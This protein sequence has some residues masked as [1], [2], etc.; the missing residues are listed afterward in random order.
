MLVA[1]SALVEIAAAQTRPDFTGTWVL[2]AQRSSV[3]GGGRGDPTAGGRRTGPGGGQGGGTG[4][5]VPPERLTIRQDANTITI[6]QDFVDR[7]VTVTYRLD[8]K[9]AANTLPMGRDRV[10]PNAMYSSGWRDARLRT[11]I[12]ATIVG[13]GGSREVEF[14]ERRYLD[15]EGRMIVETTS[16]SGGGGRRTVYNR[17]T[18]EPGTHRT[19]SE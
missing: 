13:P 18:A 9:P 3:S 8:G 12:R 7:T 15:R 16:R 6:D 4:L 11:I 1:G 10:V 19:A 14:E 2:D 5:G 17:G